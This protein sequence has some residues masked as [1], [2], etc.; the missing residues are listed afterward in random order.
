MK[1]YKLLGLQSISENLYGLIYTNRIN[2]G[3]PK[4]FKDFYTEIILS[5]V[6]DAHYKV[7]DMIAEDDKVVVRWRMLGTHKGAYLNLGPTGLGISLKGAAIYR[8][9]KGKIV[10]RWVITDLHNLLEELRE[11]SATKRNG[12]QNM[13]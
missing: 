8:L 12:I 3:G 6:P 11:A 5:A 9:E 7:D 2:Q 13:D 4:P 1:P 10:E